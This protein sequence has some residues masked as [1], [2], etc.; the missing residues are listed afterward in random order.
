MYQHHQQPYYQQ[1]HLVY[2]QYYYGQQSNY[3]NYQHSTTF[4]APL[5]QIEAAYQ[6]NQGNACKSI[7]DEPLL[8]PSPVSN[9][10]HDI[11]LQSGPP[12]G[13]YPVYHNRTTQSFPQTSDFHNHYF[14]NYQQY[15]THLS[16]N[17]QFQ[18]QN[19][20]TYPHFEKLN[21]MAPVPAPSPHEQHPTYA[22][23][24][25]IDVFTN[26]LSNTT[27]YQPIQF[28]SNQQQQHSLNQNLFSSS[29]VY[30]TYPN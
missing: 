22:T 13:S 7:F 26:T 29:T 20:Q 27:S 25:P 15:P 8:S 9:P 14:N 21:S 23:L 18:Y 28:N 17:L 6:T 16:N 30:S 11:T 4:Q 12:P 2:N 10:Q 24:A 5:N 19:Y 1:Q 3:Q